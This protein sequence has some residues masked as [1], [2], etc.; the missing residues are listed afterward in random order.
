MKLEGFASADGEVR[1]RTTITVPHS[2]AGRVIGKGGKNVREI[3][4]ISGALI[5]LPT[6]SFHTSQQEPPA[7]AAAVSMTPGAVVGTSEA[8]PAEGTSSGVT[9][10]TSTDDIVVQVYGNF[11]ATQVSFEFDFQVTCFLCNLFSSHKQIEIYCE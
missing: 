1:L 3:Q 7:G 4:R 2:T 10:L 5:K 8:D 9:S 11:I 6:H